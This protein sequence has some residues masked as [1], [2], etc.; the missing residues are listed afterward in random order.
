LTAKLKAKFQNNLQNNSKRPLARAL[1]QTFKT[2]MMIGGLAAFTSSMIQVL[3]PFVVKYIIAYAVQDYEARLLG[4]PKP[5]IAKGVGLVLTITI[6]QILGSI[7][8]NHFFYHCMLVDGQ[9]R[10][11]LISMIFDK[12]MTI[13]GRAKAGRE[14]ETPEA[15]GSGRII[16]LMAVD[17]SRID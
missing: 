8:Y 16:N 6:M 11:A 2:D 9:V 13:S 5:A 17:T 10:S 4:I 7:G 1:F 15:W 14:V 3:I 12:V